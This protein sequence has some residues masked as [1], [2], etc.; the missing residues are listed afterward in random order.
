MEGTGGGAGGVDE[1]RRTLDTQVNTSR[2]SPPA[3]CAHRSQKTS[4]ISNPRRFPPSLSL[5]IA[6]LLCTALCVHLDIQASPLSPSSVPSLSPELSARSE[7]EKPGEGSAVQS[8]GCISRCPVSVVWSGD[9]GRGQ[10]ATMSCQKCALG[11]CS[12]WP[13]YQMM[14]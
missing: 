8:L 14:S 6:L 11:L 5:V 2:P 10:S 1:W 13:W 7:S 9:A 3:F 12:T 4:L